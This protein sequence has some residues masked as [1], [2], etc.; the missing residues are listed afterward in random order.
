MSNGRQSRSLSSPGPKYL[1]EHGLLVEAEPGIERTGRPVL[2][3]DREP[4]R[5]SPVPLEALEESE[6]ER[7]GASPSPPALVNLQPQ[8]PA[9]GWIGRGR[10]DCKTDGLAVLVRD[11]KGRGPERGGLPDSDSRG[12]ALGVADPFERPD[13]R[14]VRL[15]VRPHGPFH[16]ES[17]RR[18]RQ[19]SCRTPYPVGAPPT[20]MDD[21][22]TDLVGRAATGF[23]LEDQHRT[24]VTVSPGDGQRLLLSFH[25]LAWTV[26]CAAQMQALEAHQPAFVDLDCVAVGIS[27]DSWISKQAWADEIGVTVTPLLAD[28][29]PHGAVARAYGLF[30]EKDGFSE[31]ANVVVGRDGRI[32]FVRVYPIHEVPPIDDVLAFLRRTA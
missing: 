20:D 28:F 17:G 4:D 5:A 19:W 26:P 16:A 13:G 11:E 3:R 24:P 18:A 29:W 7:R 8:D 12:V 23:T 31:R 1:G 9:G 6:E 14:K 22:E 15:A 2:R 32:A 30:R 21:P 10:A 27:V 25:P